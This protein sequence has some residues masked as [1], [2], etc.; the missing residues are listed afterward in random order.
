MKCGREKGKPGTS[1]VILGNSLEIFVPRSGKKTFLNPMAELLSI[2]SK[3]E[4]LAF[5]SRH[6]FLESSTEATT[7]EVIALA[8]ACL[9]IRRCRT[10]QRLILNFYLPMANLVW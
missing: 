6:Y 4:V 2:S 5:R 9:P 8:Y 3:T 1:Q 10:K 7:M